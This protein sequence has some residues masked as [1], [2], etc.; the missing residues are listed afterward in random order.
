MQPWFHESM[1]SLILWCRK[2]WRWV[3]F[4]T[5]WRHQMET[6]SALLAIYVRNSPVTGEFPAQ[7]PVTRSFVFSLIYTW[8]NGWVNNR[9]AGDLRRHHTHYDVTVMNKSTGY[10][11][12]LV[13][14]KETIVT[15]ANRHWFMCFI[16]CLLLIWKTEA[17][18]F[19]ADE[20]SCY[21]IPV[22]AKMNV[23]PSSENLRR[24]IS[25][26]FV[27]DT[28]KEWYPTNT[29]VHLDPWWISA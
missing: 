12:I 29:L 22:S 3:W 18:N 15:F 26:D 5:W 9:Q 8:M 17:G 21:R 25:N 10:L 11:I 1:H 19:I 27:F 24:S 28:T 7:R 2:T 16:Y 14:M 13:H 20:S 23:I 4:N 6:F